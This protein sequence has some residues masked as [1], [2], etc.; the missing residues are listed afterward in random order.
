MTAALAMIAA[1][2]GGEASRGGSA[3]EP[4]RAAPAPASGDDERAQRE[5]PPRP[6]VILARE[7]A[8][9][10]TVEVEVAR[11]PAQTSHGLMYRRE[12]APERGMLFLFARER[13]R[14][15]WMRDTFIPL[16]MIF[17]TSGMRVLGIV[18]NAEPRTDDPREVEGVSQFVLEV[19]A[20]FARAHGIEVGAEVRFEEVGEVPAASGRHDDE[21][22]EDEDDDDLVIEEWE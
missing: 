2:S 17:I 3:D 1:C 18:E 14:S 20:G 22:I 5:A 21:A 19:N 15:F 8:E 11:T 6:R 12:L 9:P 10:V 13:Q 16:D 7:G 4:R